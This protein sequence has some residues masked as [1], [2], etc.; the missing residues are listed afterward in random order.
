MSDKK[1]EF[2]HE[3]ADFANSQLGDVLNSEG[4]SLLGTSKGTDVL[5]TY[6]HAVKSR[7]DTVMDLLNRW[8]W[9]DEMMA[10][11]KISVRNREPFAI[12]MMDVDGL[13]LVNDREGHRAGDLVLGRLGK[14]IG[15]RFRESDI[16][17]KYG[18][19]E[20]IVMMPLSNLKLENVESEERKL[21]ANLSRSTGIGVSVG[22]GIWDGISTLEETIKKADSKLY[23]NK[24]NKK[25][26]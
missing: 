6:E 23:I 21:T 24:H 7:K 16:C 12:V 17:G 2:Q 15:D 3:A 18:G 11:Y 1:S 22:I 20:A 25:N 14:A 8:V 19:D 5:D 10:L 13:K 9:E 26:V 4:E